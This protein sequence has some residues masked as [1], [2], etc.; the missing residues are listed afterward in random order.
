MDITNENKAK[1]I[2]VLARIGISYSNC[3]EKTLE[4]L[5]GEKIDYL[6]L[7]LLVKREKKVW[8]KLEQDNMPQGYRFG[9]LKQIV[10]NKYKML[11]KE[12]YD[13]GMD[14]EKRRIVQIDENIKDDIVRD[15][16]YYLGDVWETY[17]LDEEFVITALNKELAYRRSMEGNHV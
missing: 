2:E 4:M 5:I 14:L 16:R 17:R 15:V 3:S 12:L 10:I 6:V 1:C 11:K 9:T 7:I 8:Q 13:S